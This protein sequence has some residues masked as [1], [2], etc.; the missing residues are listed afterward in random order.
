MACPATRFPVALSST[1][2]IL[3]FQLSVAV[4][5]PSSMPPTPVLMMLSTTQSSMSQMICHGT[6]SSLRDEFFS[7]SF[8]NWSG[9]KQACY[10]CVIDTCMSDTPFCQS[11][12]YFD[13]QKLRFLKVLLKH[14]QTSP[15]IQ[16]FYITYF[17]QCT[18][19][20][21]RHIFLLKVW[22]IFIGSQVSEWYQ[23]MIAKL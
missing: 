3:F 15:W 14:F 5:Q 23:K 10:Y 7:F 18:S 9:A 13:I 20:S 21:S 22:E 19:A 12:A 17:S 2:I 8:S 11:H 6:V 4:S 16:D 1:T